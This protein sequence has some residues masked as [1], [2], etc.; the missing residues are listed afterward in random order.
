MRIEQSLAE[1]NRGTLDGILLGSISASPIHKTMTST[2]E[3]VSISIRQMEECI[4]SITVYRKGDRGR[5]DRVFEEDMPMVIVE[6]RHGMMTKLI[7]HLP[8]FIKSHLHQ[9]FCLPLKHQPRSD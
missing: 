1:L 7:N 8:S 4:K 6:V 2:K 9:Y 3:E 5:E